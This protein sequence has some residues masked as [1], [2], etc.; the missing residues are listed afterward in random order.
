LPDVSLFCWPSLHELGDLVSV[1]FGVKDSVIALVEA[2]RLA[3]LELDC[4]RDPRCA[5]TPEW[6]VSR[7][8]QLLFHPSV[9]NALQ[10]LAPEAETTSIVPAQS[11][12]RE[13]VD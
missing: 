8:D 12:E 9:G 10:T 13:L 3:R 6:T 7:L 11:N 5:A 2:I 1:E 4:F